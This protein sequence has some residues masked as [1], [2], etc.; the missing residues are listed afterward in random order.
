MQDALRDMVRWSIGFC[1]V[2]LLYLVLGGW[3]LRRFQKRRPAGKDTPA[4]PT[5]Q[6]DP[7]ATPQEK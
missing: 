7:A 4:A 6:T 1:V 3:L 5:P 2:A